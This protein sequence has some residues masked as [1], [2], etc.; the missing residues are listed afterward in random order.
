MSSNL[1]LVK[2]VFGGLI[3]RSVAQLHHVSSNTVALLA[4]NSQNPRMLMGIEMALE[5]K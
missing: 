4:K 3:Q 1:L 2:A 5:S